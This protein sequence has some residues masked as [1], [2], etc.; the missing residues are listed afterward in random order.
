[1][2]K[3]YLPIH[4]LIGSLRCDVTVRQRRDECWGLTADLRR[5]G[6]VAASLNLFAAILL[7]ASNSTVFAQAP[8]FATLLKAA[9][10]FHNQG[11]YSHSIPIL[12]QLIER[13]PLNY[14]ANL[15]LG[16]DFFHS[17][18]FH[19][20]LG[21]LEVAAKE[22]PKDGTALTLLAEA[23]LDLGD[24]ATAA[25]ALQ[26]AVTRSPDDEQVLVRW[27]DFC[28]DRSR[29]LGQQMR[30]TK[31]GEATMLRVTAANRKD[32]DAVRES[33]LQQSATIDPEQR[34]IWGELGSAQLALG[35][36]TEAAESLREAQ[37]RE[38]QETE[39]LRLEALFAGL[40]Q[41]WSDAEKRLS[42]I[43][44]RSPADLKK[45]LASWPQYLAPEPE[46]TGI[47]WT[48]LRNPAQACMLPSAKP[49]K[50]EGLNAKDLYSTGRWEQLVA[51]PRVTA[52]DNSES[53]WQGV[54]Y[55]RTNDCPRAI[56]S[57]ERGLKVDGRVAGFWLEVC[58]AGTG[59]KVLNHLRSIGNELAIHEL[60]GDLLLRL[61]ND[62]A[63]AQWEYAEALKSRPKDPHL[64]ARL[65]DAYERV[66]E[67]EKA[68]ETARAAIALDA[69]ES[70]ALR[71]LALMAMSEREY[72][73]AIVLLKQLIAIDPLDGWTHVQ[74]G[75][76]YLQTGHP[77]DALRYLGPELAAGYPDKKGALHAQ[78]AS[79]L[80][81]LGREDEAK[82]ASA[83]ASKLAKSSLEGDENGNPNA[84]Q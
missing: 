14:E 11:D 33:L 50:S 60:K 63:A 57:L 59:E 72:S 5:W 84:H 10:A 6:K 51:L 67:V 34:G 25:D 20:A 35:K 23:A 44:L 39:T 29:V 47:I 48:C 13:D 55:A 78:L 71:T 74:L 66:G 49:Q 3:P 4:R 1:M 16:E 22:R 83:E 81:K 31:H 12:K 80:R 52:A 40:E 45:A 32:G 21:S 54:A 28:L 46:V 2:R 73:E 26:T 30:A 58:Y 82:L 37:R 76:A 70:L 65:A 18:N 8:T 79:A 61:K 17:G 24:H 75:V 19:D 77:E 69:Q 38:P 9:T 64:L 42:V 53:L 27:A 43:G 68:K 7:I 36:S 41:R 62:G 56:P 15:L